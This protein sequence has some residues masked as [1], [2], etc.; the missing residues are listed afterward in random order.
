VSKL[1]LTAVMAVVMF[2]GTSTAQAH[3]VTKPKGETLKHRLA[4]QTENLAHAKYVCNNGK[5]KTKAWHCHAAVKPGWLAKE[6]TETYRIMYPPV[7]T[8]TPQQI[9][10][11]VFGVHCQA[12]ISVA[13]CE[14]GGTFSVY[15]KN[16]QYL[17]LFQM[18]EYARS[19]YGHGWTAYEQARAA[20]R[21]FL[22]AGWSP[23]QCLP[24]GGLRW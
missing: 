6:R 7:P 9:I 3:L 12:A 16:G 14:T 23:W 20:Y 15:A 4:S 24:G 21:Y 8:G 19:T 22:D 18:G 5:G 10:C 11:Q 1:A 2:G 13:R 17:G